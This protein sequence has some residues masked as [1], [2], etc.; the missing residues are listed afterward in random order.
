M[1]IE[2]FRISQLELDHYSNEIGHNHTFYCI[3]TLLDRTPFVDINSEIGLIDAQEKLKN[4]INTGAF[5]IHTDND[6][7]IEAVPGSLENIQYYYVFNPNMNKIDYLTNTTIQINRT[8]IEKFEV[9]HERIRY[10]N[11]AKAFA[12]FSGMFVGILSG[13]LIVFIVIYTMKKKANMIAI[14]TFAFRNISFRIRNNNNNQKQD[15][16]AT[17]VIEHSIDSNKNVF[18]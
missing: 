12:I 7:L 17:I 8:I 18:S 3:F 9:I 6:L 4:G 16:P 10:S 2:S 15:E 14:G 13:C 11:K 5:Q 1:S